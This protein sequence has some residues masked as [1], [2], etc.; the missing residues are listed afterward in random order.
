MRLRNLTQLSPAAE[1]LLRRLKERPATPQV[2]H[3]EGYAALSLRTLRRQGLAFANYGCG[4]ERVW[5]ITWAGL[6]HYERSG[7]RTCWLTKPIR[8]E[9]QA[10]RHE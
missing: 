2:L 8:L 10:G 3:A 6:D 5:H 1:V 4:S 9:L 7:G